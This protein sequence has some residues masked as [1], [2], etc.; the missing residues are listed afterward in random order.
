MPLSR[1]N[2]NINVNP[3]AASRYVKNV[4]RSL[5]YAAVESLGNNAPAL[6][7]LFSDN[8]DTVQSL[9]QEIKD[10]ASSPLDKIKSNEKLMSYSNDIKNGFSNLIDDIKTGNLYNYDRQN[11]A[12]MSMMGF[13]DSD[14]FGDI[15][16]DSDLEDLDSNI[17]SETVSKE[18]DAMD[19]IGARVSS[20]V[21][22][23]TAKSAEY[24]VQANVQNT[25]A[26]LNQTSRIFNAVST[27][28][29]GVNKTLGSIAQLAQPL[30][31]HMQ[32][33]SIFYTESTKNQEKMIELLTTIA[34]NTKR[35]ELKKGGKKEYFGIDA[36]L[37]ADYAF[38]LS[39]MGSMIKKNAKNAFENSTLGMLAGMNDM[40][41]E[42]SLIKM[43]AANPIGMAMPFLLDAM[44][45]KKLKDSMKK[46]SDTMGA[47]NIKL[48]R[49]L[50]KLSRSSNPILSFIG[51]LFNY[52]DKN[53]SKRD[54]GEYEK[55]AISFDGVTKHAI[56]RV[57][58][59][60]L[61]MI[62]AQLGG[63]NTKYDYKT[64]KFTTV[65]QIKA[66]QH[67]EYQREVENLS[68]ETEMD[69]QEAFSKSEADKIEKSVRLYIS[70]ALK[71]GNYIDPNTDYSE[72][73]C[74]KFGLNAG[75][76]KQMQ[77]LIKY[78]EKTHQATK[79]EILNQQI[80][81]ARNA[82]A[83][84]TIEDPYLSNEDYLLDNS[85]GMVSGGAYPYRGRESRTRSAKKK[86]GSGKKSEEPDPDQLSARYVTEKVL[87][88][89]Y[90]TESR[91]YKRY[92]DRL[93]KATTTQEKEKIIKDLDKL[94]NKSENSGF[95]NRM[96]GEG[97]EETGISKLLASPMGFLADQ[98]NKAS[99]ALYHIMYGKD[100]NEIGKSGKKYDTSSIIG[101]VFKHMD[102][103]FTTF[104]DFLKKDIMDPIK[105][106]FEE[107]GGLVKMITDFFG[108]DDPEGL[109]AF[110]K[111]KA[112]DLWTGVKGN[113]KSVGRWAWNNSPVVQG[114]R[115]YKGK[116]TAREAASD[117]LESLGSNY[118]PEGSGSGLKRFRGGA[119]AEEVYES[120]K[121]KI[122]DFFSADKNGF[123]Y[124]VG[125][126]ISSAL[127]EFFSSIMPDKKKADSDYNKITD[128]IKTGVKEIGLDPSGAITG[129]IMGAGVSLLTG[130]FISPMLAA[131]L[132]AAAGLTIKSNAVQDLLF[133]KMEQYTDENG[134][135]HEDRMGGVFSKEVSDFMRK[136]LP[137][138][139]AWGATG[140]IISMIPGI[141]GGPVAGMLIG[142]ALGFAHKNEQVQE[143]LWGKGEGSGLLGSKEDREK[144][145]E[146]IKRMLPKAAAGAV[147]GAV[148][149][150]FGMMGNIF[151][152]AA[153]GF[154]SETELFKRYV[155]G[156]KT[157]E[158][159]ENGKDIRTGGIAGWIKK[160]II[161]PVAEA[162]API[163]VEIK[164]K[165]KDIIRWTV[166]SIA[167]VFK[168]NVATPLFSKINDY[169]LKPLAGTVVPGMAKAIG[170]IISLPF[171]AVGGLGR[172]LRKKQIRTG[173][174]ND[175]SAKERLQYRND[176]ALGNDEF[177]EF[178]TT[179]AGMDDDDINDIVRG[180]DA[181]RKTGDEELINQRINEF[182]TK[183]G[184]QNKN[185]NAK[186]VDKWLDTVKAESK[187]RSK[188]SIEQVKLD[189]DKVR[190][191]LMET[192]YKKT[193]NMLGLLINKIFKRKIYD[194]E[195]PGD[196]GETAKAEENEEAVPSVIKDTR[197]TFGTT[198]KSI[199]NPFT[200]MDIPSVTEAIAYYEDG[201]AG[202][203]RGK[204]Q[205][206]EELAK[207]VRKV[208][209]N[210]EL[211]DDVIQVTDKNGYTVT[212]QK[213]NGSWMPYKLGTQLLESLGAGKLITNIKSITHGI[214]SGVRLLGKALTGNPFFGIDPE[215]VEKTIE[216]YWKMKDTPEDVT[217]EESAYFRAHGSDL[218][219]KYPGEN[220]LQIRDNAGH[221]G[222]GRWAHGGWKGLGIGFRVVQTAMKA[223]RAITNLG[224][225]IGSTISKG[226]DAIRHINPFCDFES[227][228]VNEIIESLNAMEDGGSDDTGKIKRVIGLAHYYRVISENGSVVVVTPKFG[229]WVYVSNKELQRVKS[230][231]VVAGL[232]NL[233]KNT[234][235][236][237]INAIGNRNNVG[238]SESGSG[239][240]LRKFIGAGSQFSLFGALKTKIAKDGQEVVDAQDK[241]SRMTLRTKDKF[242][243]QFN[244]IAE[245]IKKIF[246]KLPTDEEKEEEEEKKK[247]LLESIFN[248][249]DGLLGGLLGFFTG[250]TG[251]KGAAGKILS[252]FNL[253][254]ALK[255]GVGLGVLALLFSGALNGLGE[256]IGMLPPFR[257][258]DGSSGFGNTEGSEAGS[259]TNPT[260]IGK[261]FGD[262]SPYKTITTK[263]GKTKTVYTDVAD[264]RVKVGSNNTIQSNM[265]RNTV[266]GA[267]LGNSSIATTILKKSTG[268]NLS[269]AG[270]A[271]G[272]KEFGALGTNSSVV[273]G[274]MVSVEKLIAKLPNV[275]AKIP[276]LP[277]TVK[278][279]ANE[280]A[281]V[282]YTNINT[283]VQK[284][285]SS[286]KIMGLA[287]KLSNALIIAKV[288]YVAAKGIDAWGNAESILGITQEATTG[289]RI[290]AVLI[291]VVN[292][293]I[294]IV[295]DLIP[296]NVL[297]NIFMSIAP[298]LGI[299]VSSLQEQRDAAAADLEAYKEAT[300][301]DSMTIEKYNQL[302]LTRNEDG[303][304]T[305]GKAR[306]GVL[307]KV[308][309]KVGGFIDNVKDQGFMNAYNQSS[310][311][312]TGVGKAIGG[313][314]STI[315]E[316]AKN[317]MSN[318]GPAISAML[319]SSTDLAKFI[320][321]GD[322]KGVVDYDP[323]SQVE[324]AEDN[325]LSGVLHGM[326]FYNKMTSIIPAGISWIGHKAFD[327]AKEIF[328][329]I[330][331]DASVFAEDLSKLKEASTGEEGDGVLTKIKNIW[332]TQKS[333][334]TSPLKGLFN[335]LSDISKVIFTVISA[336]SI[337]AEPLSKFVGKIKEKAEGVA[338]GVA[339]KVTEVAS[340]AKEWFDDTAVGKV[341]NH[342][343]NG[344]PSGS[345][346]FVSQVDPRVAGKRFGS[347]TIGANGCAPSVASMLTGYD[348]GTTAGMAT[349]GGYANSA[350]TSADY[351]G[352][353][354]RSAGIP[355]EYVYT[356]AGSAQ[357]YLAGR[358]A[359]GSPTVLLG[360]D[361]YNT[362]KAYSPFGPGNHYV[363]ATG[364]TS[365]GGVVVQDPE[366]SRPNMVYDKSI[367]NSV[368]LGIPTGGRSGLG[369]ARRLRGGR[370]VIGTDAAGTS[371]TVTSTKQTGTGNATENQKQ[372]WT[373][374]RKKGLSEAGAAGLMGCWQAESGNRPDRIEGDYMKSF[375]G[376]DKVA[377]SSDALDNYTVNVLFPAY[378]KIK[379]NQSAY[380]ASDGH[381]YPGFGLAQWTGGRGLELFN[382]CK[383]KH[384]DWKTLKA[385]LEFAW[386]ELSGKYSNVL[387]EL[388]KEG[389]VASMC[390]IAYNKY[391][392][393]TRAD[394][395]A[396]RQKYAAEIYTALTGKTY[397]VPTD[398]GTD[399]FTYG[400]AVATGETGAMTA[401]GGDNSS[402]GI[403]GGL[404]SLGSMFGKLFS[405]AFGKLGTL[406]GLSSD[407]ESSTETGGES[408]TGE[409]YDTSSSSGYD[410]N[411]IV[412]GLPFDESTSRGKKQ[413]ALVTK[414]S[415]I[416]GKLS[417][418]MT[419][420]RDPDKGSADCSSTVNWAYKNVLGDTLGNSSLDMFN[421]SKNLSAVDRAT[422]VSLS[423]YNSSTSGPNLAN[424]QPGDIMLFSRKWATGRPYQVGHVS[425][426][427][428]DG[429][430]LSHGSNG[431]PRLVNVANDKT[432]LVSKRYNDFL[433]NTTTKAEAQRQHELE[434]AQRSG[435]YVGESAA[436]SGLVGNYHIANDAY[437][438]IHRRH[439]SSSS[440]FGGSSR[441]VNLS[442]YTNARKAKYVSNLIRDMRAGGSATN[443]EVLIALLKAMITLL[444]NMSTNSDKI[445]GAITNINSIVES[446]SM[447]G[448]SGNMNI[449]EA[450]KGIGV[451]DTDSTLAELQT[452]LDTLA[453]GG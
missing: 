100:K 279:G 299:D 420:P 172:S 260:K 204:Y 448:S 153:L 235:L 120:G 321:A 423:G 80:R 9:Y 267:V 141:P 375:P 93:N 180:I 330:K 200:G 373:F 276:F 278:A 19:D 110:V 247:G 331:T 219:A 273:G 305:Q 355:A 85:I 138:M 124:Q 228:E 291:A 286:P 396:T 104:K 65:S 391:E 240:T 137:D 252:K 443:D 433:T 95:T 61:G 69:I 39:N 312:Q 11:S 428:G 353:V 246:G 382:F 338:E 384:W 269:T 181:A 259:S 41:G 133:G 106:Y 148:T 107:R 210:G 184:L 339:N 103:V 105:N 347:S 315:G 415:S 406:F 385:Q 282:L 60:Y 258:P 255:A 300:G 379:I 5:G 226:I 88:K 214:S 372:I 58:P 136:Q 59:E 358:I 86:S 192:H 168:S 319:K 50:N 111:G 404:L 37:G 452:L 320:A 62:L 15:D 227:G 25:R 405:S 345:G 174:A 283:A 341:W 327:K 308:K 374:L 48:I 216:I 333:E 241:E 361:P 386:S 277:S 130:G 218:E 337:I 90:S 166:R 94:A 296:N 198:V 45:T 33:S 135:V 84:A 206:G 256:A 169:F 117:W 324:N 359:S 334:Y 266:T 251:L 127:R 344:A 195:T 367:L 354:L 12:M 238:T 185:V 304:F 36:F 43:V 284:V 73:E 149:G 237:A 275:L 143:F 281:N 248:S 453:S 178:D 191:T 21:S 301:D 87:S 145:A 99:D 336:V 157:G 34:E 109:K 183:F 18:V 83:A 399:N 102:D 28:L 116:K 38:N 123:G 146:W 430:A 122:G 188:K 389:D 44:M 196:I 233:V 265:I 363:L 225:K 160:D 27:G 13:D 125:Q 6:K 71:E 164:N 176:Y 318:I 411:D 3:R 323:M 72:A 429:K 208:T 187:N 67:K 370:A 376:F 207:R 217:D 63:P 16:F 340:S 383:T 408:T 165:G 417:Y 46:L 419:G 377:S 297:V 52:D 431:G 197:R 413:K 121:Q 156:E 175:M 263:D 81:E 351:F 288:A 31:T 254:A 427:A 450:R 51:E 257:N 182:S 42:G 390:K 213:K 154:A 350:G 446:M 409:S 92:L 139:A 253:G 410:A 232:G 388:K 302:G 316:T 394:W 346:S 298:K 250:G 53:K 292:A 7:A 17:K 75:Q 403:A 434:Q 77:K 352:Q 177:T 2:K 293:L 29:L 360:R 147:I 398:A 56:V 152:G 356:G 348:L 325:P 422:G 129:G 244:D 262:K 158:K 162:I 329:A 189:L 170:G 193:E 449:N 371:G 32:N 272:L 242:F 280:I 438:T 209:I 114:Y 131:S 401:T 173:R 194:V 76:M 357:D 78:Y 426:Y 230:R 313:A 290:I 108:I 295:G 447:S 159:D 332:T 167:G 274:I 270:V 239:S 112:K 306:A 343:W 113:L 101:N 326:I 342:L 414:M 91:V 287:S 441:I 285:A 68:F 10:F 215:T 142:S 328:G 30:T 378:T 362:S 47:F 4:G 310:F 437:N 311:G 55:G 23:A 400:T 234:A 381:Y 35:P 222:T 309:M 369:R 435:A 231:S 97:S 261:T 444:S 89:G 128:V 171:K 387:S 132:G 421:N 366:S 249:E 243:A 151:A 314:L 335:T 365:N 445:N 179:L 289:Q 236:R 407:D 57:I 161:N 432:Y 221:I 442:G 264:D 393:C 212:V 268:I 224:R 303:T 436:G 186:N 418:S 79:I 163:T 24:I 395:L 380:K 416:A 439:H 199:F 349:R 118:M 126:E 1:N 115:A 70:K 425:M 40:F 14:I 98:M 144:K 49:D 245:Y 26:V 64:G 424:L 8:K 317:A 368:K 190:N 294:P 201:L 22:M 202:N 440:V 223:G 412:S 451:A 271:K 364:M 54:T 82:R 402:G 220:V 66:K 205:N 134:E 20:S 140:G 155:F 229:K 322:I 74:K 211:R 397:T 96:L 203:S 150:P 119:T 392:G 307:T